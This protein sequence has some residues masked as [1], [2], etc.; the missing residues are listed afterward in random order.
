MTSLNTHHQLAFW[1]NNTLDLT[2][3]N[4]AFLTQQLI[5]YIGNKRSLLNFIGSGLDI[6]RQRLNKNKLTTF[7]V[8]SGS[9]VVSRFLKRYS[10]RLI[11]NDIEDYAYTINKCYLSNSNTVDHQA[12][13]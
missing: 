10:E 5:T 13:H 8:F 6:V 1:D 7:D 11:V 12:L 9:G 3:E 4:E 2:K